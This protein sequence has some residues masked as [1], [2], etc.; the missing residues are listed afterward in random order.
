MKRYLRCLTAVALGGSLAGWGLAG[1]KTE[2]PGFSVDLS[3]PVCTMRGERPDARD[4]M[5]GGRDRYNGWKEGSN[6]HA[7]VTNASG[8]PLRLWREWCR[9]GYNTLKLEM[10]GSDGEVIPCFRAGMTWTFD[11]PDYSPVAPGEHF[12]FDI[13]FE[14]KEWEKPHLELVKPAADGTIGLRAVF[15]IKPD[16]ESEKHGVW[17]GRVVSRELRVV[18]VNAS[19]KK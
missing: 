1:P 3:V 15:E 18:I 17:T 19:E 16:A 9:W 4:I 13:D 7:V 12:V 2:E 8:K 11:V 14:P 6:F 5:Y 10:I